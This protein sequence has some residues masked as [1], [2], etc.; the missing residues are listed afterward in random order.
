MAP[1]GVILR[2]SWLGVGRQLSWG[3]GGVAVSSWW[4]GRVL[5][6]DGVML[7]PSLSF[8]VNLNVF[9]LFCFYSVPYKLSLSYVTLQ[10]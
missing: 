4:N 7:F 1:C 8:K 2:V 5:G 10:N 6:G 3:Q 9:V